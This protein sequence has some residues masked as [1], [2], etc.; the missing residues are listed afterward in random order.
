MREQVRLGE[1]LETKSFGDGA[2]AYFRMP[3]LVTKFYP[4]SPGSPAAVDVQPTVNDVRFDTT[5]GERFSEPWQ[6]I[7]RVP[8]RYPSGG[9]F[10]LWWRLKVGDQVDLEAFDL[11]PGPFLASGQQSD[12]A[13]TRRNGGA[14]WVAVPGQYADPL[15]LPDPGTQM[16]VGTPGGVVVGFDGTHVNLGSTSPSDAVAVASIVDS[17]MS[18]IKTHTHTVPITGPAG[19]TPT[20]P[21]AQ[22][23]PPG[24]VVPTGSKVVKCMP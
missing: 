6:I 4:A 3:G 24:V 19:T 12:P 18:A 7:Y 9:G 21:S 20:S 1:V 15:A 23:A 14:H 5:T 10:A 2:R 17:I 11:D 16:C 8:I 22:L 13:L